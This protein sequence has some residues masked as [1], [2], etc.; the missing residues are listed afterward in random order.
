MRLCIDR[1]VVETDVEREQASRIPE[2]L[3]RAFLQLAERWGK[4]PW[5]R[6]ISL[7]RVVRRYLEITP[8]SA[9]EL[10]GPSGADLLADRLWRSLVASVVEAA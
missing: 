8:V 1:I 5:A 2:V 6:S 7:A 4:S 10:L 9:D 3:K